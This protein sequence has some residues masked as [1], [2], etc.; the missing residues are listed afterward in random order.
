MQPNDPAATSLAFGIPFLGLLLSIALMPLVAPHFW[1]RRMGLIALLWTLALVVPQAVMFGAPPTASGA[2]HAIL[3]EYL[4]FVTLLLALFTAGGGI[5]MAAGRGEGR[6]AIPHCWRSVRAGRRDGHHRRIDGADPS[7]VARQ[8]PPHPEGASGGVF[9]SVGGQ[10]GRRHHPAGRPAALPRIS[11]R[12]AV[13]LAAV[14][15]RQAIAGFG[16]PAAGGVLFARPP[17]RR[18]RPAA[19]PG[20]EA[21]RARPGRTWCFSRRWSPTC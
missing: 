7:A 17:P 19:G 15:S 21:H 1:H 8:R 12:S 4:P 9:H 10:R 6:P 3:A 20:R 16:R 18:L 2:W 11:A 13:R 5:L 14:E